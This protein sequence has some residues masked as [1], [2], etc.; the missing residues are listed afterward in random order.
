MRA[1][2]W[3]NDRRLDPAEADHVRDMAQWVIDGGSLRGL[4]NHLDETGVK[5][6]SGIAW[7]DSTVRTILTSPRLIG[8]RPDTA[9]GALVDSG[10]EPVL[11]EATWED[12]QGAL[13]K[14]KRGPVTPTERGIAV[15]VIHCGACGHRMTTSTQGATKGA[16]YRCPADSGGCGRLRISLP[17]VDAEL[18]E[19]LLLTLADARF[20]AKTHKRLEGLSVA[21]IDEDI[22]AAE[23]RLADLGE[24][25]AA[26]RLEMPTVVTATEAIRSSTAELQAQR[27]SVAAL[28][29]LPEDASLGKVA[30]WWEPLSVPRKRQV[31]AA[32][33]RRIDVAETQTRGRQYSVAGR[34][35][36][37]WMK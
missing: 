10:W 31:V 37:D 25:F 24:E 16:V 22:A 9:T 5:T 1:F 33:I 34:L 7:R 36:I 20:L 12:L 26:G 35:T 4:A 27:E 14:L 13:G 3:N 6:V 32:F 2:G 29:G 8:K 30:A 28:D 18:E 23:G 11:T 15:G 17:M 21:R 19:Q